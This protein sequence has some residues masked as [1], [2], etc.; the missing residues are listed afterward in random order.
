MTGRVSPWPASGPASTA[1]P[2]RPTARPAQRIRV[3]WS[4]SRVSQASNAAKM[5]TAATI[6]PVVELGRCFSALDSS[7]H[8]PTISTR[9]NAASQKAWPLSA[10]R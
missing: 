6:R 2:A 1:T 9:V 4:P 8:G 7:A 5:G 10:G 3:S